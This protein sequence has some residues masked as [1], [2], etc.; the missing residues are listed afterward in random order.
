MPG[1]GHSSIVELGEKQVNRKTVGD[2][3]LLMFDRI[4]FSAAA[5]LFW[6]RRDQNQY[7]SNLH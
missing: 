2:G 1:E 6:G 3:W 4:G 5:R 7:Y